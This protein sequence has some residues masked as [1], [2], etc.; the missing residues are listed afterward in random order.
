MPR[1]EAIKR[2]KQVGAQSSATVNSEAQPLICE[3]WM[4]LEV[5]TVKP[6]DPVAQARALLE[7]HRINQ[8]PVVRNHEL[9]GIVTD[10]D[11]RDAMNTVAASAASAGM[12]ESAPTTP[13][14]ITVE[15]V[16]SRKLLMLRPQSPLTEAAE[17]MV[18]ERIGGVPIVDRG[19]L[20]GIITRSDILQA[21]IALS[22][23]RA[24]SVG[25]KAKVPRQRTRRPSR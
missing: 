2:L 21:F 5:L 12:T 18:R 3:R 22:K 9:L 13:E 15:A 8:L 16:M 6:L 1:S 7:E 19:L 14:Q 23:A 4:S 24:S 11:L 20:A 17:L 10:R 25:P